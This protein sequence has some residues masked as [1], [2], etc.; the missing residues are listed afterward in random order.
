MKF[1]IVLSCLLVLGCH[2]HCGPQ[3]YA[4]VLPVGEALLQIFI[5]LSTIALIWIVSGFVAMKITR[6]ADKRQKEWNRRSR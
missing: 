5:M 2:R 1:L 3:Q 4:E 6:K